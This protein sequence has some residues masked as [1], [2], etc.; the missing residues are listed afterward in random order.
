[1]KLWVVGK[2]VDEDAWEFQGVFGSEDLAVAACRDYLDCWVGP[3]NLNETLP[4][5]TQVEW[6]GAYFPNSGERVT[7]VTV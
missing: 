6:P 2:T 3:C 4:Y 5:E 1:M 7:N